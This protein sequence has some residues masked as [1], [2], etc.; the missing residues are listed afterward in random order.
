V[1]AWY[2]VAAGGM[3]AAALSAHGTTVARAPASPAVT[4]GKAIYD[5]WCAACHD[6]GKG[7]PGTAALA[8]KYKDDASIPPEL[9]RRTDLSPELVKF[10][11]RNGISI[12]PIFRK[13]E[14]SDV[15]L[16][17]LANYLD[18]IR[19]TDKPDHSKNRTSK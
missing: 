6:G 18:K 12:M 9:E 7:H 15:E 11:V 10:V 1:K 5:R 8:Y 2:I 16:G 3:V 17:L 19:P 4:P 14:I 13:T